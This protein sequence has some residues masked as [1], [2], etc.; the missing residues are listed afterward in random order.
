MTWKQFIEWQ[1]F[2]L[3]EPIGGQRLDWNAASIASV[4]VN[5]AAAKG[6]SRKRVQPKDMLLVFGQE[7][8][9]PEVPRQTWQHQ[10]MIGM[11]MAAMY[12]ADVDGASKKRKRNG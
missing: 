6:R 9:A 12:N 10:K 2:D 7:K 11:M 4:L 1:Q 8:E 5:I 3:I